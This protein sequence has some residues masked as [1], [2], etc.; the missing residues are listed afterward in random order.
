MARSAGRVFTAQELSCGGTL[1]ATRHPTAAPYR[2]ACC[3]LIAR[4]LLP[5]P[6]IQRQA[7][8]KAELG[9]Y[10]QELV[11]RRDEGGEK[12]VQL[13]RDFAAQVERLLAQRRGEYACLKGWLGPRRYEGAPRHWAGGRAA[14]CCQH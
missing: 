3:H 11:C 5:W 8:V 9:Q 14:C 7:S 6:Q 13:P 10:L 12:L 4:L 2:K 1:Q